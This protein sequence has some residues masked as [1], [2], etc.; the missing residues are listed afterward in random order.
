MGL[1]KKI[2]EIEEMEIPQNVHGMP[3]LAAL[4]ALWPIISTILTLV[5]VFTGKKADEK[6]DE[7]L[8]WGSGIAA[9]A[10]LAENNTQ[11]EKPDAQT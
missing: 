2:H 3:P 5:K 7:V 8:K 9:I 10:A 6:I 4:A 11:D 1:M